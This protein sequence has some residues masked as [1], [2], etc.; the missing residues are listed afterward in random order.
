[1]DSSKAKKAKSKAGARKKSSASA[2]NQRAMMNQALVQQAMMQGA[3]GAINPEVQAPVA[4]MQDRTQ[5]VNPYGRMGTVSPNLYN[6]GNV[7]Y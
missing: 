6:P 2:E 4:A 5:Q 7:V 1:M 3:V